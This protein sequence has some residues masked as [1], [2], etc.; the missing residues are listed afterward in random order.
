MDELTHAQRT[1]SSSPGLDPEPLRLPH[2]IPIVV[3][4]VDETTLRPLV[5]IR[6]HLLGQGTG[7]QGMSI[8]SPSRGPALDDRVKVAVV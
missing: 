7:A 3:M 5:V 2:H 8:P 6:S 4:V 1:G